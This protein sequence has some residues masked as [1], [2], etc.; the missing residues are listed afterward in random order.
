MLSL[1]PHVGL[2]L[3]CIPLLLLAL[4]FRSLT[5][6]WCSLVVVLAAQLAD[7][8][9]LRPHIAQ[10]SVEIG[11]VVPWVVALLGYTIYG[12]G[13]AVYG[14]IYAVFGLAVLDQ[15]ERDEPK[16]RARVAA[17]DAPSQRRQ[18]QPMAAC[19]E[20]RACTKGRSVR[21]STL[22]RDSARSWTRSTM[23]SAVAEG[24]ERGAEGGLVLGVAGADRRVG[25]A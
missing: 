13:G 3:G 12:I 24:A 23:S 22:R 25:V 6:R 8:F 14:T 11:L 16:A 15:L 21:S 2:T 4:G 9:L 7:S 10:Q 5:W 1:F 19:V 17:L 20:A 18:R